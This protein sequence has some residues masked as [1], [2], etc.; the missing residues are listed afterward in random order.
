MQELFSDFRKGTGATVISSATGTEF[1]Y[2]SAA[3][4]N[5][6]FTFSLI[7]GLKSK[8]ADQNKD[9]V[10][11]VSELKA[12]ALN[13][14]DKLTQGQQHP[15]SRIEN[16]HNNFIIA[17]TLKRGEKAISP[18]GTWEAE[19]YKYYKEL[20]RKIMVINKTS[21]SDIMVSRSYYKF[22]ENRYSMSQQSKYKAITTNKYR[23]ASGIILHFKNNNTVRSIDTYDKGTFKRVR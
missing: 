17:S 3:W 9:N 8:T 4:N 13:N 6:V 23:H 14:V 7:N 1:A 19:N 12:Y 15:T 20:R 18:T 5:G 16:T 21:N 2:E 22:N 11:R 10:I